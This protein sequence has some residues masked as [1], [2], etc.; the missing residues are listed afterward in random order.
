MPAKFAEILPKGLKKV[1]PET[2]SLGEKRFPDLQKKQFLKAEMAAQKRAASM[3]R[4]AAEATSVRESERFLKAAVEAQ[5]I[6]AEM[7][8]RRDEFG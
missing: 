4:K 5:K 8:R 2:I 3:R 7:R 6:E 1:R